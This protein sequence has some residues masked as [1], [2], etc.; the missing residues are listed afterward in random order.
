MSAP[1]RTALLNASRPA[2]RRALPRNARV[3]VRGY[4]TAGENAQQ[5]AASSHLVSGLAGGGLVLGA[6]YG[7]YRW[8]GAAEAVDSA[9]AIKGSAAAAKEKLADVA[10]GS[11]SE[12]LALIKSVAKSYASAIPGGAYAIDRTFSEIEKFAEEHGEAASKIIKETYADVEEAAKSGK[13]ASEGIIKALQVAGEKV[14]KLV[15]EQAAQ[16]WEGLQKK[17]P[18]LAEQLGEGGKELKELTEKHGPEAQQILTDFYQKGASIVG[19]SKSG[20]NAETYE[21]VKQLLEEKRKEVATFSQKAGKDAWSSASKAAGPALD[22]L[23]DVKEQIEKNLDKVSGYVGEDRIKVVKDVYS[24]LSKIADGEGSTEEKAKKAKA[25][26]EE[27][28]GESST[29]AKLGIDKANDLASQGRKWLESATGLGGLSK[30][31]EEVDLA[32]LKK[33]ASEKGDD[34]KKILEEAYA[35]IK[36]VLEK[37]G[38][39]AKQLAEE[40]KDDA[41]SA[42]T[43]GE[44]KEE[45]K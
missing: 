31:F 1:A 23:P 11:A 14:Q 41:K 21:K 35:D 4:A 27:K 34:G 25:L 45:K 8:S 16:G 7:Y 5:Q 13:D 44:K 28:L 17:Y 33:V 29:F 2:A 19:S 37:H 18:Q 42:A 32:S 22:K 20:F 36:D 30:V 12:A 38:K 39:R 24:Q 26:V 3:P 9:R 10:P 15:G 40:G 6:L 43:K